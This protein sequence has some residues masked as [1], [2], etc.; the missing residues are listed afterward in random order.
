MQEKLQPL[1]DNKRLSFRNEKNITEGQAY[2]RTLLQIHLKDARYEK[3]TFQKLS[4]LNKNAYY[5]LSGY[6]KEKKEEYEPIKE[7]TLLMASYGLGLTYEEAVI[8]FELFGKTLICD[9]PYIQK[10]NKILL[11]LD[12]DAVKRIRPEERRRKVLDF[13]EQEGLI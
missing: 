9:Y 11:R 8:L 7:Q 3:A 12:S 5:K 13:M 2:F 10:L 4:G 6:S 1:I